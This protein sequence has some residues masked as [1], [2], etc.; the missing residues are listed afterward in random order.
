MKNVHGFLKSIKYLFLKKLSTGSDEA[1]FHKQQILGLNELIESRQKE[2]EDKRKELRDLKAKRIKENELKKEEIKRL[3]EQLLNVEKIKKNKLEVMKEKNLNQR[4][5]N[6]N[7][8]LEKV[9]LIHSLNI[10]C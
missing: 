10:R 8:H 7:I 1:F 2:V 4:K 6:E 3:K 5:I 9:I